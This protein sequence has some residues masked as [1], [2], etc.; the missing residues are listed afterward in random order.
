MGTAN[1]VASGAAA[2]T[3]ISPGV[4]TVIGAG[5]GLISSLFGAKKGA[6]AAKDSANIQTDFA[7]KA[8]DEQKRV[9]DLER[10]DEQRQRDA[11]AGI[12]EQYGTNPGSFG[13]NLPNPYG[14]DDAQ[15]A[16]LRQGNM[17]NPG[18]Q[19]PPEQPPSGGTRPQPVPF[20]G[21]PQTPW[22][23][24]GMGKPT[25]T[26][27][28]PTGEIMDVDLDQ[29]PALIKKGAVIIPKQGGQNAFGVSYGLG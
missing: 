25:V 8:L 23:T 15:T 11:R 22:Q 5:V 24:P 21:G 3:A 16:S 12:F 7:Q 29:A 19:M 17:G 18:K 10:A 20:R 9:Y 1:N 28:A 6:N 27:Q 4:G 2:G 14:M 13:G 26:L